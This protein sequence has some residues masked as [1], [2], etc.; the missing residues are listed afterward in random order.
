M[1][2]ATTALA[3]TRWLE[4][5]LVSQRNGEP[6]LYVEYEE[7]KGGLAGEYFWL[8]PAVG[9]EEIFKLVTRDLEP[10]EKLK[11]LAEFEPDYTGHIS[12]DLNGFLFEAQIH[13]IAFTPTQAKHNNSCG[14]DLYSIFK[15]PGLRPRKSGK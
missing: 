4:G 8:S 7:P 6:L 11:V 5:V 12:R 2:N 9:L 1:F 13:E 3:E 15:A 10:N 14:R